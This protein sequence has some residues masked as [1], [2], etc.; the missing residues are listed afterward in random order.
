VDKALQ[1]VQPGMSKTEVLEAAGNPKRTYREHGQDH[2]IYVYFA[3]N[4]ELSREVVFEA[5]KVEKVSRPRTKTNWAKE[6]EDIPASSADAGFNPID[7][8]AD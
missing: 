3:G 7:D 2:W 4:R 6:L 5:G 8:T 1:H